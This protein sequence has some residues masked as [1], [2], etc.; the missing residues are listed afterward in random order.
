MFRPVLERLV[1]GCEGLLPR[2]TEPIK[3][4]YSL[5]LLIKTVL[6][7][8]PPGNPTRLAVAGILA[9]CIVEHPE[10]AVRLHPA[11]K[12]F[13]REILLCVLKH[14]KISPELRARLMK[15]HEITASLL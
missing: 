5:W 10:Y 8:C 1:N 3:P 6:K 2:R 15:N 12:P 11:R 4:D 9:N 13:H 14:P 7:E